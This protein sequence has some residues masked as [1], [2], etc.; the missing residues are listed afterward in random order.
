M[1]SSG[2][3]APTGRTVFRQVAPR[4]ERAHREER[5][6]L[7]LLDK[8]RAKFLHEIHDLER[9]VAHR[10]LQELRAGIAKRR[11]A[12]YVHERSRKLREAQDALQRARKRQ[13]TLA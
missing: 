3:V 10:E 11:R 2:Q 8:A 12:K 5:D 7:I 4:L 13:Q 9:L 1:S 6:R